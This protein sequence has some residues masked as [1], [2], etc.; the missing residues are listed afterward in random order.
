MKKTLKLLSLTLALIMSVSVLAGCFGRK[1]GEPPVSTSDKRVVMTLGGYNVT[2]DFYRY[3]FHNTKDFLSNGDEN[4]WNQEGNDIEKVKEYIIDSL[5]DTYA[6]FALADKYDIKLTDSEKSY[7]DSIIEQSKGTMSD[8]DFEKS[9]NESYMTEELY[10]FILEIQQLEL[11]VYDYIISEDSGII[12]ADDKTVKNA[13]NNDFVRATH[14]LFIFADEKESTEK[15]ALAEQVLQRLKNG[16]DFETLKEEFSEDTG[17]KGNAHGYYFIRGAYD[18]AFEDTAFNLKVGEMSEIIT[19]DIGYHIVKRLPLEEDYIDD[20]L[21]DLR[22][23]Y[24]TSKYYEIIEETQKN[25]KTEYKDEYKDIKL[26]SF[27]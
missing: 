24:L 10:R 22:S 11:L 27:K 21:E 18:N 14:I 5:N 20:N 6:M 13:V 23:Q 2:Y 3:L 9:L 17:L 26:D 15:M 25:F 16:E 8:E 19:S 7:I 4:Y 1:K 12:F